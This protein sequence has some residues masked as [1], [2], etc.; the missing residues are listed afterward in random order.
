LADP[1][2]EDRG[3]VLDGDVDGVQRVEGDL[4][5]EPGG[6]PVPEGVQGV[7]DRARLTAKLLG[8]LPTLAQPLDEFGADLAHEGEPAVSVTDHRAFGIWCLIIGRFTRG[9]ERCRI[10]QAVGRPAD[11]PCPSLGIPEITPMNEAYLR[12]GR[13][14]QTFSRLYPDAWKQVDEFRANRKGLG[15]WSDWCFLPLVGAYAIVSKGA[16]I[17]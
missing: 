14:L 6:R 11:S 16:K 12:P 15:N 9:R 7:P 10:K 17:T 5:G 13:T 3:E 8:Q 2:G 1:L 4:V